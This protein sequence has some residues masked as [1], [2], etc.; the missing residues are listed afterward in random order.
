[1][2]VS[3]LAFGGW[4]G[5]GLGCRPGALDTA[6]DHAVSVVDLGPDLSIG[7]PNGVG[8]NR[9]IGRLVQRLS[10]CQL[11]VTAVQRTLDPLALDTAEG[12]GVILM[13]T[14]LVDQVE[15][16]SRPD[17]QQAPTRDLDRLHL[18]DLEL[19]CVGDGDPAVVHDGSTRCAARPLFSTSRTTSPAAVMSAARPRCFNTI[20]PA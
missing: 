8:R 9:L 15:R 6:F 10:R 16:P 2:S 17:K 19:V 1:M 14:H 11:K 7:D 13:A 20:A 12:E 3:G 18:V 4:S 5:W